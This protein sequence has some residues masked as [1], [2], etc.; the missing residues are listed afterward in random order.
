M[1]PATAIKL[2]TPI[3][4][5]TTPTSANTT[6]LTVMGRVLIAQPFQ[7]CNSRAQTIILIAIT[8]TAS[9]YLDKSV[10]RYPTSL[11]SESTVVASARHSAQYITH[12]ALPFD[13]RSSYG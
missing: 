6:G 9:A 5:G 13:A 11:F 7:R 1:L 12:S 8:P 3:K 2:P 4:S 10:T